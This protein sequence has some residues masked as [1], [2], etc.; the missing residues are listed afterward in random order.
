[1]NELKQKTIS[2][3]KWQ[4]INKVSQ[5]VISAVTFMILARILDPATF[6]LFAMAFIAID[7]LS[8][9][10]SFGI[11]SAIIQKK[12]ASQ[13]ALH[14]AFFMV[15]GTGLLMF[16]ACFLI[17]PF[18]GYFF[19]N[20]EVASVIRALGVLF[21]ISCFGRISSALLTKEMR[22]RLISMTELI[23]SV[24]NSVAAV[25]FALISPTVWSLVGAYLVKQAVMCALW[26]Y[27]SGYRLKWQF[28]IKIA[29]ELF[30]YGKFLV[31][32]SAL[33][34]FAANIN[35]LII[36]KFLDTTALGYFA[37]A[38]NLSYFMNS[39]FTQLV[40]NV[41]FPAYSTIQ[42]DEE[43]LKRAYLKTIKF[44]SII[45]LPYGLFLMML[46]KPLVLALYGE[47]W[48]TVA[49]LVPIFA[50]TQTLTPIVLCAGSIFTA[51][52]KSKY[53][54]YMALWDLVV[55]AVL[56]FLF[57]A[58]WG[59]MGAAYA[60]LA[61]FLIFA[62]VYFIL[63]RKIV[64]FTLRELW[65]QIQPAV[66]CAGLMVISVEAL[67]FALRIPSQFSLLIILGT[68]GIAAYLISLFLIDRDSSVEIKQMI[69]R[70]ERA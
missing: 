2:G 9:F 59:I 51:C 39:H 31:G 33:W 62:P 13:T 65:A 4:V 32:V 44:V 41:M 21:V 24:V 64:S 17:A 5:K 43:T 23:G 15:Q 49:S 14:T 55:K 69:F 61:T 40:S 7:A 38:A 46:A 63:L 52:G 57:T 50:F 48:L 11:D 68:S 3:I 42:D 70:L 53:S 47:K 1:M 45:A 10:K 28:D 30:S 8:L 29:K 66:I 37:L 35:G 19:K 26:W 36:A 60:N 58:K 12:N 27:F 22:F 34:F 56:V 54:Y 18:A 67:K 6:G 16:A 25:A 20:P